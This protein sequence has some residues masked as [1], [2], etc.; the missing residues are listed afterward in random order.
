MSVS[1]DLSSK[2]SSDR[3]KLQDQIIGQFDEDLQLKIFCEKHDN[4]LVTEICCNPNCDLQDQLFCQVCIQKDMRHKDECSKFIQSIDVGIQQIAKRFQVVC[5]ENNQEV[6]RE[7][8]DQL[9]FSEKQNIQEFEK[10]ISLQKQKIEKD[11]Q[12]IVETFQQQMEGIKADLNRKMDEQL[13]IYK[14]NYSHFKSQLDA[15]N[16]A[17]YKIL[18]ECSEYKNLYKRLNNSNEEEAIH[19]LKEINKMLK[20]YTV[21]DKATEYNM[22]SIHDLSI[23]LTDQTTNPPTYQSHNFEVFS[24]SSIKLQIELLSNKIIESIEQN[25]LNTPLEKFLFED[26]QQQQ[27]IT[28]STNIT[29]PNSNRYTRN[30]TSRFTVNPRMPEFQFFEDQDQLNSSDVFLKNELQNK[31]RQHNSIKNQSDNSPLIGDIRINS[32]DWPNSPLKKEKSKTIILDQSFSESKQNKYFVSL[33]IL[34]FLSGIEKQQIAFS[35]EKK[36]CLIRQD[37][38]NFFLER[39]QS[40]KSLQINENVCV[41]SLAVLAENIVAI[42]LT[43]NYIQIYLMESNKLLQEIECKNWIYSLSTLK[44]FKDTSMFKSVAE[45]ILETPERKMSEYGFR[46]LGGSENSVKIWDTNFIRNQ[47]IYPIM[48]FRKE[49]FF[50]GMS[51][52]DLQDNNNLCCGDWDGR[53]FIWDYVQDNLLFK[54]DT[55]GQIVHRLSLIKKQEMF[56]SAHRMDYNQGGIIL[57]KLDYDQEQQKDE[58]S[59]GFGYFNNIQQ[60]QKIPFSYNEEAESAQANNTNPHINIGCDKPYMIQTVSQMQDKDASNKA[61]KDFILPTKNK[62]IRCTQMKRL[63]EANSVNCFVSLKT[64]PDYIVTS[65]RNHIKLW[66]IKEK[67]LIKTLYKGESKAKDIL[68]IENSSSGSNYFVTLFANNSVMKMIDSNEFLVGQYQLEDYP[69]DQCRKYFHSSKMSFLEAQDGQ[70]YVVVV[71]H[72][73]ICAHFSEYMSQQQHS[74]IEKQ[75][76]IQIQQTI[77]SQNDQIKN[78]QKCTLFTRLSLQGLKLQV[79]KHFKNNF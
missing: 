29:D 13:K 71:R 49:G 75:S 60:S 6:F 27:S 11:I 63:E 72:K 36:N 33:I 21:E 22:N 31:N 30:V 17:E 42:G 41:T 28:Q 20:K 32:K 78:F 74:Q 45:Q 26:L 9:T 64:N 40:T 4:Q 57:W 79:A 70:L 76:S 52:L 25:L 15:S 8:F 56:I 50:R 7:N 48:E 51:L 12:T 46:L 18:R 47:K 35:H 58:I 37:Q 23:L 44:L 54:L 62:L 34:F 77:K 14:K 67:K 73:H 1:K 43:N 3:I 65:E 66:D 19:F 68:L 24:L 39:S 16:G 55:Q 38:K 61:G 59:T 69:C 10:F 53:I 5:P 2:I